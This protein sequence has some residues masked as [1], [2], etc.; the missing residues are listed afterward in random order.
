MWRSHKI[1]LQE[2]TYVK[3]LLEKL[4]L[5]EERYEELILE[6][7]LDYGTVL[8]KY[9]GFENKIKNIIDERESMIMKLKV[10]TN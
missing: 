3:R 8:Q 9:I 6:K 2:Q 10:I 5:K 1:D 7:M 4:V